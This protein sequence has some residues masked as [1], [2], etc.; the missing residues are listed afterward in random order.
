VLA[1]RRR[2]G[3][4]EPTWREADLAYEE[5]FAAPIT[6]RRAAP[7][8][9]RRAAPPASAP[10]A[11]P[12]SAPAAPPASARAGRVFDSESET[13]VSFRGIGFRS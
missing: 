9:A 4:A 3:P 8:P 13:V 10:A 6:A 7:R 1:L 12:A 5:D 2:R 11:P